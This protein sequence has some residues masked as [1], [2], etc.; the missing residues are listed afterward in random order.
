MRVNSVLLQIFFSF[1]FTGERFTLPSRVGLN[2]PILRVSI[3]IWMM[4]RLDRVC[5]WGVP[6]E[7]EGRFTL[8][9]V[10]VQIAL[11]MRVHSEHR[12]N[13]EEMFMVNIRRLPLQPSIL[14][15]GSCFAA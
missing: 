2:R 4:L 10:M 8:L 6:D 1:L 5:V 12:C 11:V 9:H 15:K 7:F 13:K 3:C 14:D